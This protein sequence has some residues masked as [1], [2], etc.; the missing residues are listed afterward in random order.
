M[1]AHDSLL[2]ACTCQNGSTPLHV[3]MRNRVR[4]G[5]GNTCSSKKGDIEVGCNEKG[6]PIERPE[7]LSS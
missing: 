5:K 4:V 2:W 6:S 3:L 7:C 1:G